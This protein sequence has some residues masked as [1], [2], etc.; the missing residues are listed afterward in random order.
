MIAMIIALWPFIGKIH[1]ITVD[2]GKKF[3]DHETVKSVLG[4]PIYFVHPYSSW[5]CDLNENTNGLIR[6]YLKKGD[7]LK[8]PILEQCKHM[9]HKLNARPRKTLNFLLPAELYHKLVA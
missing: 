1:R 9:E 4:T 2:N 8:G 6:Q 5:R 7:S 3:A